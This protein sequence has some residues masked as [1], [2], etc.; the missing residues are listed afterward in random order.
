MVYV[1]REGAENAGLR[2]AMGDGRKRARVIYLRRKAHPALGA[3]RVKGWVTNGGW[4]NVHKMYR[5]RNVK[6][7]RAQRGNH[8]LK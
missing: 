5:V 4:K 7:F 1:G 8:K 2:V 6:P 3:V